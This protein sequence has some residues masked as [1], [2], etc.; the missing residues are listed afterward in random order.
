VIHCALAGGKNLLWTDPD[1]RW[2]VTQE[3]LDAA[4]GR[5]DTYQILGG[6]RLW[7]SPE[8]PLHSYYPDTDEVQ[9]DLLPNGALFTPPPRPTGEQHSIE[10]I[11]SPDKAAFTVTHRVTNNH[12]EALTL[13]PWAI[14]QLAPGGVEILPQSRRETGLLA[15]RLFAIWPYTDMGD[16]RLTWGDDLILIRPDPSVSRPLKIGMRCLDGWALYVNGDTAFRKNFVTLPDGVYPD[17][18]VN[19]ET[20]TN[21]NFLE[22]ETIG[23]FLPLLPGQTAV[24]TETWTLT[25]CDLLPQNLEQ[26]AEAVKRLV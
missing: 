7:T 16:K 5:G 24:H 23:Q 20:Y 3:G 18:G 6:H 26:A 13:A 1:R 9:C 22:M 14:T 15:D 12:T 4:F 11:L 25:A 10:L 17:F 19:F 21:Q 8:H 2:G